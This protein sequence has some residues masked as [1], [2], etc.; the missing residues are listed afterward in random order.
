MSNPETSSSTAAS[1][2]RLKVIIADD[3]AVT[4]RSTR[5]MIALLPS[6]EVVGIAHTGR[7]A[8]ALAERLKPDMALMDVKMP[9]MNGLDAIQ[10]MRQHNPSL[11]CIILS[12]E[13]DEATLRRAM[14]VGAKKYLIKPFTGEQFV[15]LMEPLV[16]EIHAQRGQKGQAQPSRL[17]TQEASLF[18]RAKQYVKERRHDDTAVAL[19][20]QLIL[21]PNCDVRWLRHLAMVYVLRGDWRKLGELAARLDR[22]SK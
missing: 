21:D 15:R 17:A 6:L 3:A 16:A 7:E 9:D 13:K 11:V 10:A 19:F 2:P 4:R 8:V 20:E 14:Q 18:A 1:P 5:M 22:T 12:A